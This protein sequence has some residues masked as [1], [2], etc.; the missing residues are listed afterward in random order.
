MRGSVVSILCRS[1]SIPERTP[2]FDMMH[3]L[4]LPAHLPIMRA[5][6]AVLTLL[7]ILSSI[8]DASHAP[9]QPDVRIYKTIGATTLKAHIF[10]P[11][12]PIKAI[13]RAAIVLLHGGGWSTGSPEWMSDDAKRYSGLG[14]VA[15]AGEHRLSDQKSVTALD[16]MAD[17][18]ELIRWV[19]TN[20]ADLSVD[21]HRIAAYG[22]SAGGHFAV[23]A[24]V[25]PHTEEGGISAVPDTLVLVS[26]P[27]SL[28]N[29]KWP[30]LLLGA[31]AEAKSVSPAEN[32]TQRLPPIVI[33]EGAADTVTPPPAAR[34]FCDRTKQLGGSCEL[35]IY[36]VA[37]I[38]ASG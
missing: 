23:S 4:S 9:P 34:R 36:A 5:L 33:I 3:R 2:K 6:F 28:L 29:D 17:V 11:A 15:I 12:G 30:Q 21:P 13:Q 22:V 14:M 7:P 25:F 37:F 24:A 20:A 18:R 10:M 1:P 26:S 16:A 31:H 27:V 19:R 8:A 35:H 38:W 32:V